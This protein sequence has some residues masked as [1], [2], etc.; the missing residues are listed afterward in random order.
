MGGPEFVYIIASLAK[1]RAAPDVPWLNRWLAMS[2]HRCVWGG[3]EG[4]GGIKR[5]ERLVVPALL[6]MLLACIWPCLCYILLWVD[7]L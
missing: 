4:G 2:R 5:L 6:V 7:W 1:L 3:G